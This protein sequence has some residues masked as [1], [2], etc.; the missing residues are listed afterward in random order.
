MDDRWGYVYVTKTRIYVSTGRAQRYN[1]TDWLNWTNPNTNSDFTTLKWI[2]YNVGSDYI[3]PV[4]EMIAE[5]KQ[6]HHTFQFG[7]KFTNGI[8]L[9]YIYTLY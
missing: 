3:I 8:Y 1:W 5:Q 6:D 7:G 9:V 2:A 4:R